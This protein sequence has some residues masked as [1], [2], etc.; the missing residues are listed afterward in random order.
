MKPQT[1]LISTFKGDVRLFKVTQ[2]LGY[3]NKG[4]KPTWHNSPDAITCHNTREET[5]GQAEK[6][7]N[8]YQIIFFFKLLLERIMPRLLSVS[9][10]FFTWSFTHHQKNFFSSSSS[11]A[12][13]SSTF[14]DSQYK[15]SQ[16]TAFDSAMSYNLV[17]THCGS[18]PFEIPPFASRSTKFS[19]CDVT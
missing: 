12:V 13:T 11:Y 18:H 16:P 2:Q 15:S 7:Q 17:T 14:T 19:T 3:L 6:H 4:F 5:T 1:P 8:N 10:L 9:K